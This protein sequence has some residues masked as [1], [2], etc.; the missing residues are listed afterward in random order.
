MTMRVLA[1]AAAI[2][3]A[4]GLAIPT[5]ADAHGAKKAKRDRVV[6]RECTPYNGP[7]GYYGDPWCEGGW[8]Y[9][10]DYPPGTGPYLDVFDLPQVR[11]L[12]RWRY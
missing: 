5:G 12:Q 4:T 7:F 6:V 3:L 9:A 8:K 1:L 10:E 2:G 11:R